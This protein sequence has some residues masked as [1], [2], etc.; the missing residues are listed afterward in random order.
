MCVYIMI[1]IL[2]WMKGKRRGHVVALALAIGFQIALV[3]TT[4]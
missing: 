1:I 4:W 2:L 3:F